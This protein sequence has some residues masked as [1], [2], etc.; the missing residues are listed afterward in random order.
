MNAFKNQSRLFAMLLG[1]TLL[2]QT[3]SAEQNNAASEEPLVALVPYV[4]DRLVAW[5][6]YEVE[7]ATADYLA[8]ANDPGAQEEAA[9]RYGSARRAILARLTVL[10]EELEVAVQANNRGEIERLRPLNDRTAGDILV[11]A[12]QL[13]KPDRIKLL[14]DACRASPAVEAAIW[15]ALMLCVLEEVKA[16]DPDIVPEVLRP[17]LG[18]VSV[19]AT[20]SF[21]GELYWLPDPKFTAL[22]AAELIEALSLSRPN[23]KQ[24]QL[25]LELIALGFHCVPPSAIRPGASI[26]RE[27]GVPVVVVTDAILPFVERTARELSRQNAAQ[28]APIWTFMA[29]LQGHLRQDDAIQEIF[30]RLNRLELAVGRN[31]ARIASLESAIKQVNVRIDL[32]N[33][34][35]KRLDER[36]TAVEIK[37]T[38]VIHYLKGDMPPDQSSALLEKFAP[39]L[40]HDETTSGPLMRPSDFI[41]GGEL[42]FPEGTNGDLVAGAPNPL[43]AE[44]FVAWLRKNAKLVPT[45]TRLIPKEARLKGF[46]AGKREGTEAGRSEAN[47]AAINAG[48]A[49]FGIVCPDAA[50]K[51]VFNIKYFFFNA[52]NETAF[53]KNGGN[54]E[55]DWG[56]ID[57][58]VNVP[59]GADATYDF[60][61]ASLLDAIIH[62]HGN[63]NRYPVENLKFENGRLVVYLERGT[64]EAHPAPGGNSRY[65]G[66]A[67]LDLFPVVRSHSGGGYRYDTFGHV[68]NLS[69]PKLAGADAL[70]AFLISH[71][72]GRWGAYEG[73]VDVDLGVVEIKYDADAPIGPLYND[74]FMKRV[75]VIDHR[76]QSKPK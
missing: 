24:E 5:N 41:A 65:K 28:G 15:N 45:E 74:K 52:Y 55:G 29:A 46:A 36:L 70:N 60:A 32:V 54:H 50:D 38:D 53:P 10:A 42:I 17:H 64:N 19:K 11:L 8:L 33:A 6:A 56:A 13:A 27:N 68:L 16:N 47:D 31:A 57:L 39:I 34:D 40:R 18:A 75:G 63:P 61:N 51:G 1:L 59:I 12:W 71:Y 4:G 48:I 3:V 73:D 9:T 43:T 62:E 30:F 67:G 66:F 76:G 37:L 58:T 2:Y 35:I 72:R 20:T 23:D 49:M 26:R 22:D 21:G 69:D 14:R 7:A 25:V 44:N